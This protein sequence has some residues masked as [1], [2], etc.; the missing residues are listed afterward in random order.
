M[1]LDKFLSNAGVGSRKKV[2]YLIKDG[3]VRVEGEIIKNPSFEVE[4]NQKVYLDN[5]EIVPYHKVYIVMY[6]PA[7]FTSSKSE[8]ERNIFEFI[9]HPYLKKLHIVGRLDKDV[10]GL[11]LLTNDG[12]FTHKVISPKSKIEKEYLVRIEGKLT[13]EKIKMV[14]RGIEL[15][16][17]VKFAP[18]KIKKVNEDMISIII[19]EGKFHEVKLITKAIGLMYKEIVRI[20]IG[21]LKLED[22]GLHPGEWVEVPYKKIRLALEK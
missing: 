12:E 8:F 4:E 2:K 7:G 6:K 19:T 21:K 15:K 17:G 10:R 14:E 20:R 5:D 9:N 22:F 18:A 16:N 13:E 3:R 11:L 1:R